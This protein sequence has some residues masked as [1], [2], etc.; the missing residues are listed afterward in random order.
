M[1]HILIKSFT[2]GLD[3]GGTKAM[4]L[5]NFKYIMW[6]PSWAGRSVSYPHCRRRARIIG[7]WLMS[8]KDESTATAVDCSLTDSTPG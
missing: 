6:E 1:E 5:Y 3:Y 7:Q 4:Q 8:F 2:A